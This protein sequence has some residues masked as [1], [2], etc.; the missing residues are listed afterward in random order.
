MSAIDVLRQIKQARK[1]AGQQ[2]VIEW[3]NAD[4]ISEIGVEN[5]SRSDLRNHLEARDLET[6]GTRVE[7]IE[8]LRGSISDE[9]LNRF[10][11][12][13]TLDT[14]F[15]IQ[16]DIEQRGSVYVVGRNDK[17]QLGV[18]DNNPRMVFQAVK[19]LRGI[20]VNFIAAGVD[21]CFAVTEGH[22]VYV[23]GGGGVGRSGINP[24]RKAEMLP[25][26]NLLPSGTKLN[27]LEPQVAH[28]FK[29]YRKRFSPFFV[30]VMNLT[31]YYPHNSL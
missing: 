14:E 29:K 2:K 16:A 30:L 27:W 28:F 13:E 22:D 12:A 5:L 4:F 1:A 15:L 11:Y 31:W 6:T 24:K 21:I 18:G 3:G 7:L 10:A 17:G 23:W 25:G 26:E 20:G 9:Q 8:R 19:Q